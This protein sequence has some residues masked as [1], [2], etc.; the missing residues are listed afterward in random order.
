[1]ASWSERLSGRKY[2][3]A[4]LLFALML[5]SC[6]GQSPKAGPTNTTSPVTAPPHAAPAHPYTV[7]GAKILDPSG[8][9]FVPY[10]ITMYGLSFAQ[11]QP[12]VASDQAEINAT[13]ADWHG[14]TVRLQVDPV[15]MLA[16]PPVAAPMLQQLDAEVHLAE[17]LDMNVIVSAQTE[18]EP[19][20]ALMPDSNVEGF[21]K[22]IAPHFAADSRVWF[23]LFNEPRLNV[24]DESEYWRV[25][26]D[27]G[28][29]FVGMQQLVDTIRGVGANNIVLAEGIHG[30]SSLAGFLPLS[31]GN[32]VYAVHPYFHRTETPSVWVAN[33]GRYADRVPV[34]V[35][36][37]NQYA[38]G[39]A[40]CANDGPSLIPRFLDYLTSHGIGLIVWTLH[41]PGVLIVRDG[42]YSHPVSL[43]SKT[44]YVCD[45]LPTQSPPQ[46]AGQLVMDLF[47]ARSK[48]GG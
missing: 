8:S 27:G 12:N 36:E 41:Q 40:E 15:A 13:S 14:N 6:S 39:R 17:Q 46:G 1:M 43:D 30:G 18:H 45:G 4:A 47:N 3:L 34:I 48:P 38:S 2:R 19:N 44:P 10:G 23:D 42:D 11:W 20:G 25:W 7:S 9:V 33:W 16:S 28:Q 5:S 31:G 21:W 32:I 24:P 22:V 37:W 35:G 29:G 26:H